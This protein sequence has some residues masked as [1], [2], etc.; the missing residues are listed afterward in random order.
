MKAKR[1]KVFI[2]SYDGINILLFKIEKNN[3]KNV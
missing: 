1:N 2:V 3:S